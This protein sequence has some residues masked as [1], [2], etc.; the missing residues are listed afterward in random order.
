MENG[1]LSIIYRKLDKK[2][3]V[4][5]NSFDYVEF[6]ER[7]ISGFLS[8]Q[9]LIGIAWIDGEPTLFEAVRFVNIR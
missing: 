2:S 7:P 3:E 6:W 5:W 4:Q 1:R 9:L 8:Y